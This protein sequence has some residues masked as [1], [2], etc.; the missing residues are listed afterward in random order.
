MM[1][2][3]FL[4]DNQDNSFYPVTLHEKQEVEQVLNLKS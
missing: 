1:K 2:Y 3:N 4:K